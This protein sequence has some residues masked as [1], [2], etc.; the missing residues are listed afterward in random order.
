MWKQNH[1]QQSYMFQIILKV[2]IDFD[3]TMVVILMTTQKQ[4]DIKLIIFAAFVSSDLQFRIHF[5]N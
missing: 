4:Y 1:L 5:S 3:L 2:I